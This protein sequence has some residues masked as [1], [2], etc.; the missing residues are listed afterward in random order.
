MDKGEYYIVFTE[1]LEHRHPDIFRQILYLL[2]RRMAKGEG[3]KEAFKSQISRPMP[4]TKKVC[5]LRIRIG[6]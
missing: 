6:T 4:T 1:Y 5:W 3:I 2:E